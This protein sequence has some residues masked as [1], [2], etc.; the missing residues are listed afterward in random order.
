MAKVKLENIDERKLLLDAWKAIVDVQMHFND[1]LMR[2]RNLGITLILAVF[3]AAAFSLQYELYLHTFWKRVHVAS[4]IIV[5]GLFAWIGIGFLDRYYNK[6]LAGAVAKSAA[7]EDIYDEN[8]LG[9]THNITEESRKVFGRSNLL[10]AREQMT[11]FLYLPVVLIGL[12]YVGAV[13][14]WFEPSY[15]KAPVK[16]DQEKRIEAPR[17][18]GVPQVQHAPDVEK[19][20]IAPQPSPAAGPGSGT[21]K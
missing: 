2:V 19:P 10:K 4:A 11:L 14:W 9:M 21:T 17:T 7:L 16:A 13:V 5:F 18:P 20:T 3:G 15:T 12:L 1:M 6:L 8:W